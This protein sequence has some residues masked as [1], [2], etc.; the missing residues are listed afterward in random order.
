MLWGVGFLFSTESLAQIPEKITT[1]YLNSL[2][3][4]KISWST[5]SGDYEAVFTD[6][7]WYYSYNFPD[8]YT[9]TDV[10]ITDLTTAHINRVVFE[11]IT[12]ADNG[13]AIYSNKDIL[14]AAENGDSIFSDNYMQTGNTVTGNDIYMAGSQEAPIVLNLLAANGSI[15]FNSGIDGSSYTVNIDGKDAGVVNFGAPIQN[16]EIVG[17]GAI[18]NVSSGD[19]LSQNNSLTVNGGTFNIKTLASSLMLNRLEI[20]G[21]SINVGLLDIDLAAQTAGRLMA[22]EYGNAVGSIKVDALRV[23]TD[24]KKETDSVAFVDKPLAEN[25]VLNTSVAQGPVWQYD[26]S[27][28]RKTGGFSFTRTGKVNPEVSTPVVATAATVAVLSDE[29]Y[30]R[31]LGNVALGA[32]DVPFVSSGDR[33]I[34]NAWVKTFASEDSV[35]LKNFAG[36]DSRFY[37]VI[38]GFSSDRISEGRGWSAVYGVYGAYAGGRQEFFDERLDNNGNTV[39]MLAAKA[40]H[41]KVVAYLLE[42]NTIDPDIKNNNRQSIFDIVDEAKN[43]ELCEMLNE[44]RLKKQPSKFSREEIGRHIETMRQNRGLQKETTSVET[45]KQNQP[46][47][48]EYVIQKSKGYYKN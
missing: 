36:A 31:V 12:T 24:G 30:S 10:R 28:D 34:K 2:T 46:L 4:Q 38:G 37:G 9:K 33:R 45:Q 29:I 8:G 1:E 27:Y 19:F 47:S 40:G 44:I 11:D 32:D 18:V 17:N 13:G 15:S 26:V 3:S 20:N 41:A 6:E 48:A 22:K 21:G 25:V 16:A 43:T 23:T 7:N 35:D 42:Q 39:L 5:E 14:I